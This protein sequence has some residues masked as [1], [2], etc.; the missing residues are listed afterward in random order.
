[1]ILNK[2]NTFNV[3]N[4]TER[5]LDVFDKAR[6]ILNASNVSNETNSLEAITNSISDAIIRLELKKGLNNSFSSGSDNIFVVSTSDDV[7]VVPVSNN[8]IPS[9]RNNPKVDITG[10]MR[11]VNQDREELKINKKYLA[12]NKTEVKI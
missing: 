7:F 8:P 3:S 5:S 9:I 4:E 10:L 12:I 11:T 2:K 1:M 6:D